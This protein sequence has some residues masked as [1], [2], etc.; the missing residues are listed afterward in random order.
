MSEGSNFQ[1]IDHAF[2]SGTVLKFTKSFSENT[3]EQALRPLATIS[4]GESDAASA[5][6]GET[7]IAGL[8]GKGFEQETNVIASM[9][10]SCQSACG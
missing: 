7:M 4:V 1:K 2:L 9:C 3:L 6:L 10:F 5:S 8:I